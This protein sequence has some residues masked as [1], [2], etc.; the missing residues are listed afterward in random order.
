MCG[1]LSVIPSA[2]PP[3]SFGGARLHT[4]SI[5]SPKGSPVQTINPTQARWAPWNLW[6]K[7]LT[8]GVVH[9]TDG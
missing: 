3:M 6:K 2:L 8:V 1:C 5:L 4:G 9:P 7:Q